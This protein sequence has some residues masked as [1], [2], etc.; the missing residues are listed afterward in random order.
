MAVQCQGF[1]RC[2]SIFQLKEQLDY[3]IYYYHNICPFDQEELTVSAD[4]DATDDHDCHA[5][6]KKHKKCI[7]N[8]TGTA[9]NSYFIN[10]NAKDSHHKLYH[11]KTITLT[12][13]NTAGIKIRKIIVQ[14]NDQGK[15]DCPCG[16]DNYSG[17]EV[18]KLQSHWRY[19]NARVDDANISTSNRRKRQTTTDSVR[20]NS[21]RQRTADEENDENQSSE[22][23]DHEENRAGTTAPNYICLQDHDVIQ[24]MDGMEALWYFFYFLILS[25][26]IVTVTTEY[27]GFFYVPIMAKV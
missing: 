13:V 2:N 11:Q 20:P 25:I 24:K 5:K 14:I 16:S 7:I 23:S 6:L 22:G 18:T 27:M 10:K 4:R 19:C 8:I 9:C 26:S 17:L 3:H 12:V 1:G 15:W 21:T